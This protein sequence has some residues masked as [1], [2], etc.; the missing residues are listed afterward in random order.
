MIKK[1]LSLFYFIFLIFVAFKCFEG[2]IA[3]NAISYYISFFSVVALCFCWVFWERFS[4]FPR[5]KFVWLGL[6]TAF[7]ITSGVEQMYYFFGTQIKFYLITAFFIVV[8]G[9]PF[10]FRF[11]IDK[12]KMKNR[13]STF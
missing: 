7:Y 11:F 5:F 6:F 8:G 1:F 2:L 10:F 9:M 3:F 12:R 4:M 13:P